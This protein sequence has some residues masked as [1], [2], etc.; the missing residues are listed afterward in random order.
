MEDEVR[1]SN[2]KKQENTIKNSC[3]FGLATSLFTADDFPNNYSMHNPM[4]ASM[5]R[6][7]HIPPQIFNHLGDCHLKHTIIAITC[8][9]RMMSHNIIS[10]SI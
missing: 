4:N 5:N 1:K 10:M 2:L 6:Q 3:F 9:A 7:A 8:H